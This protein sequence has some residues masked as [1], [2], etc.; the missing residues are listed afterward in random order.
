M[1]M[2][3]SMWEYV[4]VNVGTPGNLKK[5]LDPLQLGLQVIESHS[6]SVLETQLGILCKAS[7]AVF[8]PGAIS[9]ALPLF[10]PTCFIFL[11]G[12]LFVGL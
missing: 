4:T 3:V 12:F 8:T 5:E 9:R 2:W 10:F 7:T 6:T 11:H 1:D